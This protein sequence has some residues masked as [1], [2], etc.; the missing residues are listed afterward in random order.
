M[1]KQ[2]LFYILD[3]WE[4]IKYDHLGPQAKPSLEKSARLKAKI[5]NKTINTNELDFIMGL[6]NI[7]KI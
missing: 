7:Y 1:N 5:E 2:R 6:A 4:H 3:Q